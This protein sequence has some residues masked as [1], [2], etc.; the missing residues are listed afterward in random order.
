M[1]EPG[2]D[3]S[4]KLD[5]TKKHQQATCS[6]CFIFCVARVAV[7]LNDNT[8]YDVDAKS[9]DTYPDRNEFMSVR[10]P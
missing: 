10:S 9:I 3:V 2:N 6:Q 1:N 4:G 5:D 7:L 8:R